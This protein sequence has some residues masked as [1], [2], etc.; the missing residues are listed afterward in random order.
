MR[1][2]QAY[3]KFEHDQTVLDCFLQMWRY[4]ADLMFIMSVEK[5]GEFTLYDNNPA[6][7]KVMGLSEDDKVH[8]LDLRQQFGDEMAEQVFAT[9][10][11]VIEGG[12]PISIE[13]NGVRGD[14]TKIYFDTLF[15]PI[16]NAQGE[17]IFVCG[18]SRDITKIKDAEKV[19]LQANEKLTEYSLAL[20]SVNQDLDKKV[21]E[22]TKE[23]ERAKHIA[24]EALEAKSSFVAHMSHEIRTPINAVIGLSYLTL[25]TSLNDA[26]R[27]SLEKILTAGESLLRIVNDVLDFSK[28]EAGRMTLEKTDFSAT[29]LL[30]HAIS[31]N[32]VQALAKNIIL[33]VDISPNVPAV[34]SGDPLRI[35]QLLTNLI[36]NAVKF[37]EHGGVKVRL[38]AEPSS[39]HQIIFIGE[40]IDTGIGISSADQSRLFESFQ[41][42]D[43]SIT[44]AYGGTGLGLA[45]CRQICDLMNGHLEVNSHVGMGSTFRFE[46]P[47]EISSNQFEPVVEHRSGAN[48]EIPNCSAMRILLV[49]DNPINQKVMMGYLDETGAQV[50]IANNGQQA[51]DR[52]QQQTFDIVLMDIQMPVM[53]GLTATKGIRSLPTGKQLPIFAMTAH[54]SEDAKRKSAQAGMDGHLDKPIDKAA[55]YKILQIYQPKEQQDVTSSHEITEDVRADD[56][57]DELLSSISAIDALDVNQ[58]I[59]KLDGKSVFY[60]ELVAEFCDKYRGFS[61]HNLT[62]DRVLL[63]VHSLKSSLLYIGAF[64]LSEAC[65]E[66][67]A[68]LFEESDSSIELGILE[69]QLHTLMDQ[70]ET[71]LSTWEKGKQQISLS[72]D[73]LISA[74]ASLATVE[75]LLRQSDFSVE[76]PLKELQKMLSGT[77]YA[78][79]VEN[80]RYSVSSI[81]FEHA[82]ELCQSLLASLQGDLV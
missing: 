16:F 19:A 10:Q 27:D 76:N 79:S 31:L 53:D 18:T 13:Q 21:T 72:K 34:L 23:L 74:C 47:L 77:K 9:Y 57:F 20:E 61:Y 43:D 49:E 11:Q 24:E 82:A 6:S 5:N 17:A 81:E 7:K 70:L 38:M 80:I 64:R 69:S 78:L 45:I 52:V 32:Q 39:D 1:L 48:I 26:Q 67:E 37:T 30:Q 12:K 63:E 73:E 51:I 54:V 29:K 2:S 68:Q 15:V 36:S 59:N 33:S 50:I 62:P 3:D 58:A 71:C 35:Q 44:R 65:A 60:L 28:A 8:R 75:A 41:Q 66:L 56:E 42:A 14:G 25:K 40:V 4:S 46:L 22:R 55:L